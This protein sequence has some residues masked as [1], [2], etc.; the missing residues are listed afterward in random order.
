MF[1]YTCNAAGLLNLA[2]L[3]SDDRLEHDVVEMLYFI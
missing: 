1:L 3:P 2:A